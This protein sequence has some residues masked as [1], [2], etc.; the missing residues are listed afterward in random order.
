MRRPPHSHCVLSLLLLAV[1]AWTAW[2]SHVAR[3]EL[4]LTGSNPL[5]PRIVEQLLHREVNEHIRIL[6]SVS[7]DPQYL[8]R[9]F[10]DSSH[11]RAA[12]LLQRW[13]H[14]AGLSSWIDSLANVRG[15][16]AGEDDTTPAI[17]IGSHY[18]TVIDAGAYDGA[19]GILVGIA[20][21]KANILS[22]AVQEGIVSNENILGMMVEGVDLDCESIFGEHG[23]V[24]RLKKP[25]QVV[26]FSDEEGVRFQS[27]FLGSRGL[28]GD[29]TEEYLKSVRDSSG[30][31]L[32]DAITEKGLAS[33]ADEVMK[34]AAGSG[35]LA[36]Y[37][38]V[39]IEQGPVLEAANH[40]LG[41]VTGISGQTWAHVS[42]RGSQGHAGT[43]PMNTRRDPMPA[44]GLLV[45]S[46]ERVCDH[47]TNSTGLSLVCTVGKMEVWPG[48]SNV[49]P[50]AVNF[51]V[52]IRSQSDKLR[53][54]TVEDFRRLVDDE[55]LERHLECDFEIRHEAQAVVMDE[56]LTGALTKAVA[57][58]SLSKLQSDDNTCVADDTTNQVTRMASGAGHDA[59]AMSRIVPVSML[60]VRCKG[61]ISHRPDEYAHPDDVAAAAEATYHFIRDWQARPSH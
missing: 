25:V 5:D 49:I 29:I 54:D 26:A 30:I 7:D 13:M 55:C 33:T 37:V 47:R 57:K 35:E 46:L 6:S 31:T 38:E 41:V 36:G 27:T 44:A 56:F 18:D 20:A 4:P 43:V 9:T 12:L 14:Q 34:V 22:A 16:V 58:S 40:R 42:L 45:H 1:T 17:L 61:G 51:T 52:D 2:T 23:K 8:K 24:P 48:A 3:S 15:R 28:A 59:I 53:K 11:R 60:F 19:L 10:L 21:V 39:H 50:G 32:L